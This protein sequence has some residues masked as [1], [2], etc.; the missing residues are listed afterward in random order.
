MWS[1]TSLRGFL[2]WCPS[3]FWRAG[4]SDPPT[5]CPLAVN[6]TRGEDLS[7]SQKFLEFYV[8]VS[9]WHCIMN[10][11]VKCLG[12]IKKRENQPVANLEIESKLCSESYVA[13]SVRGLAHALR[14]STQDHLWFPEANLLQRHKKTCCL[15]ATWH[16][17]LNWFGKNCTSNNVSLW[18]TVFMVY[19][20]SVARHV[21]Y[22]AFQNNSTNILAPPSW[23]NVIQYNTTMALAEKLC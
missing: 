3:G 10:I 18:H 21:Q 20:H 17:V 14:A 9:L 6:Q 8:K 13:N 22:N 11:R 4:R 23:I 19:R 1:G 7:L 15:W 16:I 2:L 5:R 12:N